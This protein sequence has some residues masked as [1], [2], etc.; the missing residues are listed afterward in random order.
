MERQ[1]MGMEDVN[2]NIKPTYPRSSSPPSSPRSIHSEDENETNLRSK[3][4]SKSGKLHIG[5]PSLLKNTP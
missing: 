2:R 3:S 1:N 5:P 4:K